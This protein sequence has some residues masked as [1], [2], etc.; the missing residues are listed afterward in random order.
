M[1]VGER[2]R[3]LRGSVTMSECVIVCIF[4]SVAVAIIVVSAI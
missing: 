3:V 2:T 4:V 1:R